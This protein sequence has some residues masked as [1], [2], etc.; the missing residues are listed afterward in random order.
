MSWG[1]ILDIYVPTWGMTS[2]KC[3]SRNFVKTS[4]IGVRDKLNASANSTSL[5][6]CPGF[7]SKDIIE[8][9]IILYA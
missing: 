8:S 2:T 1:L 3:S 4:R 7:N 5:I 9:F 6:D